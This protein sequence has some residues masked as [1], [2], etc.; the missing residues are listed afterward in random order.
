M[1]SIN[2]S[3]HD[4]GSIPEIIE[5]AAAA[6]HEVQQMSA[7]QEVDEEE[8]K[9]DDLMANLDYRR[10]EAGSTHRGASGFK[11]SVNKHPTRRITIVGDQIEEP[12]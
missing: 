10:S 11:A 9:I 1:D 8:Q 3:R 12:E 5:P 2:K 7:I 4:S 6:Q